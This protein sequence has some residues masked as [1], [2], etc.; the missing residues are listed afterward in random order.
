MY[1]GLC[2]LVMCSGSM[3][4]M[5]EKDARCSRRRQDLG[6][7]CAMQV[8]TSRLCRDVARLNTQSGRGR[9]EHNDLRQVVA[10]A[11]RMPDAHWL[12]EHG[13]RLGRQVS[14]MVCD[15][16][17]PETSRLRNTD[18]WPASTIEVWYV[19]RIFSSSLCADLYMLFLDRDRQATQTW[20]AADLGYKGTSRGRAGLH[21]PVLART[22]SSV[23]GISTHSWRC[24]CGWG[25]QHAP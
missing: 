24:C 15:L 3:G 2:L 7:D 14:K 22:F 21:G 8:R 20:H 17:M 18:C 4:H 10:C 9:E 11:E 1:L 23:L 12:V 5:S 25:N 13:S 19:P 6:L 16:S